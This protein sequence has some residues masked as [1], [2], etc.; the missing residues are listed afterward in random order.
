M[1]SELGWA[2]SSDQWEEVS[3]Y[4]LSGIE[5]ARRLPIHQTV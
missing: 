3:E 5:V 4:L 2:S 1:L